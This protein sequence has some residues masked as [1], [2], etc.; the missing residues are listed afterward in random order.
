MSSTSES[1][2]PAATDPVLL[3][4]G[5]CGFCAE[6]VQFLLRHEGTRHDLRFASLERVPGAGADSVVWREGGRDLVRSDAV[7]AA[8]RYL[9]GGW[10]A[11]GTA[12]TLVPRPLRDGLYRLVARHRHRLGGSV[13]VIPTPE[14][15]SRFL[16]LED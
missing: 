5:A 11:L 9:G 3:Y 10:R 16:D 2:P 4:D 15:R 13:C 8:A 12:A 1:A 14:Q 7:M 6:S